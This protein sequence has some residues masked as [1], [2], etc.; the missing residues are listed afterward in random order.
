MQQVCD[1]IY[2]INVPIPASAGS[3][4]CYLIKGD[5]RSVLVDVGYDNPESE[6]LINRA[7]A[8][9]GV[10][11][12]SVEVWLTHGHADHMGGID[13]IWRS[14]MIVRAGSPSFDVIEQ[15][16]ERRFATLFPQLMNLRK[17]N[18]GR[19]P[20]SGPEKAATRLASRVKPPI[21]RLFDGDILSVGS[22]RF[23]AITTPGHDMDEVCFWEPNA[24]IF[25]SGDHILNAVMPS[26]YVEGFEIDEVGYYLASIDKVADLPVKM[27]LSGHDEPFSHH[28]ERCELIKANQFKRIERAYNIVAAGTTEFMDICHAMTYA[29]AR[30]RWEERSEVLQWDVIC[31][32]A[33]FLTNLVHSGRLQMYEQDGEYHFSV[34]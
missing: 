1:N 7:L 3:V 5:D 24:G 14:G 34:L 25:L 11:W 15:R 12:E 16:I 2:L 18:P 22:Y 21:E 6:A 20:S 23:H 17:R 4:N 33:G 9:T 10:G 32:T 27:I 26:V 29:S 8:E 28:R 30:Q 31:E 13:R 19:L